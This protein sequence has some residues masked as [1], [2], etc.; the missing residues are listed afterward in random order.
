ME[1]AALFGDPGEPMPYRT[2]MLCNPRF[3]ESWKYNINCQRCCFTY[4]LRRRGYKVTARPRL[5]SSSARDPVDELREIRRVISGGRWV[6]IPS[7]DPAGAILSRIREAGPS[8]WMIYARQKKRSL[9]HVFVIEL[10][11]P[12]LLSS[13]FFVWIDPQQNRTISSAYLDQFDSKGI[14]MLRMDGAGFTYLVKWV[15][16][17]E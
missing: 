4:E 14:K 17:K 16:E 12:G 11:P 1:L 5:S 9:G 8:R 7:E 10:M 15:A 3:G 13:G 2:A 6:S